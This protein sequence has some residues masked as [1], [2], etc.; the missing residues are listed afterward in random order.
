MSRLAIALVMVSALLAPRSVLADVEYD[1]A[2]PQLKFAA[3]EIEGAL[4][5]VLLQSNYS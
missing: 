3:L 2:I 5:R 4:V 1:S